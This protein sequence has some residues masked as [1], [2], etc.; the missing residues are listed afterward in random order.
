MD[1]PAS[2]WRDR[3]EEVVLRGRT[4]FTVE[5]AATGPELRPPLLV[6]HGFPTSSF[7]DRP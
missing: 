3:G 7:S 1:G 6:L 5:V 2:A 4:I